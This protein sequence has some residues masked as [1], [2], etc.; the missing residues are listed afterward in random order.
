[1]DD[2]GVSGY[3]TSS[4]GVGLGGVLLFVVPN[5]VSEDEHLVSARGVSD[6]R[7]H[8]GI[9]HFSPELLALVRVVVKVRSFEGRLLLDEGEAVGGEGDGTTLKVGPGIADEDA[10]RDQVVDVFRV[11]VI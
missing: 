7:L 2:A 4:K 5:L 1:M 3:M 9:V 6:K 10:L 11:G 8:L